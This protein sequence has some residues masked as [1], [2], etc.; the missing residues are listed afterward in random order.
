MTAG[1]FDWQALY[2]QLSAWG[3][4]HWSQQLERLCGERMHPEAHG[5]LPRWLAAWDALPAPEQGELQLEAGQSAVKVQGTLGDTA[6]LTRALLE[7]HPWRKGPFELMGVRIDTEWRS[8]WKW[9]RLNAQLD[10]RDLRILDVGSGN[11]YYGWQMLAA[12]AAFVLGADP[13]LLY[14]AQCE[15]LRRYV[16]GPQRHFVLPLCDEDLPHDLR[17]FDMALSMGVLYHRTSPI[18]HLKKLHSTLVPQGQLVL[19][20]LIVE[21]T[22]AHV[23]V[24]EGRYAKMRNVWFLP[25]LS[26]LEIW[27]RRTGFSEVEVLDVSRTTTEEQRRT[28]WMT[29]ESLED[30]LDPRDAGRTIEGYPAPVRALVTA[31]RKN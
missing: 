13:F 25:S 21:S 19:E 31:R 15:V 24:P 3:L 20:T 11:G 29:F 2:T 27:L 12:G 16:R 4:S 8:D 30:F 23:L 14:V 22:E 1:M 18:D 17:W 5:T 7:F 9:Q 10:F 28:A 6:A 26:M